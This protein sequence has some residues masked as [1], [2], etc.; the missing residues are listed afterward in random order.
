MEE[1]WKARLD[2]W[3][4]NWTGMNRVSDTDCT[5]CVCQC[6]SETVLVCASP[7][8]LPILLSTRTCQHL[9]VLM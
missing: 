2:G 7:S 8:P 9:L 1:E 3:G 5:A 4:G 6:V